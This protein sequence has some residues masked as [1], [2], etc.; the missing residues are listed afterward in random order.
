MKHVEKSE[1]V[2]RKEEGGAIPALAPRASMGPV[3][4]SLP[5]L[6]CFMGMSSDTFRGSKMI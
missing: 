6:T 3:S 5:G 4:R 2:I 1:G